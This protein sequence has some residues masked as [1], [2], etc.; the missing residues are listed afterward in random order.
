MAWLAAQKVS[1]QIGTPPSDLQ[2]GYSRIIRHQPPPLIAFAG[3]AKSVDA[4]TFAPEGDRIASA[5]TDGTVAVWDT[6]TG[7]RLLLLTQGSAV[8]ALAFTPDGRRLAS[9]SF[10]GELRIWDAEEGRE[11]LALPL[12]EGPLRSLTFSWD[13]E[14]LLSA[15]ADG[16]IR[17][18]R[19]ESGE[20]LREWIVEDDVAYAAFLPDEAAIFYGATDGSSRVLDVTTGETRAV[21]AGGAGRRSPVPFALASY[22]RLALS[23]ARGIDLESGDELVDHPA[24][25]ATALGVA[26]SPDGR[27]AV[28]VDGG[29]GVKVWELRHGRDVRSYDWHAAGASCAAFSPDGR[30]IVSG[31]VDGTLHLWDVAIA[32][33]DVDRLQEARER[34]RSAQATLAAS[35]G[36]GPALRQL[37]DW[38]RFRGFSEA[39]ARL[40]L[41]AGSSS[42]RA[43]RR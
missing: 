29:R 9:A 34:A 17:L 40:I 3:H 31:G 8:S 33:V 37:S 23:G 39:S 1:R 27:L 41:E 10:G 24:H 30:W 28:S 4:V 12:H 13:G 6:L 36:D 42:A 26:V 2:R 38:W 16:A 5:G 21:A 18:T 15:G 14:R 32:S 11:L 25:A 20:R 35:P 43:P 19:S 7:R 22:G